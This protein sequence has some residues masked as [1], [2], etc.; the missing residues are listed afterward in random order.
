MG[1]LAAEHSLSQ[2]NPGKTELMGVSMAAH[3]HYLI[4]SAHPGLR[5]QCNKAQTGESASL[6]KPEA[7]PG[8]ICQGMLRKIIVRSSQ[9]FWKRQ[10]LHSSAKKHDTAQG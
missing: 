1:D 4:A 10:T 8:H 3:Q 9:I 5:N 6:A 2:I 7:F